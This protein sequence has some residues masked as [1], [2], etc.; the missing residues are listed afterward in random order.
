MRRILNQCANAA[1]KAKGSIFE[2]YY[3]RV[4][5]RLGNNKAVWFVAHKICTVVWVVLHGKKRYIEF[6]PSPN[7]QAMRKRASRL[8]T[9]LRRL[10]YTVIPPA[11]EAV[12]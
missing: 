7:L 11:P 3:S 2:A 8:A 1:V 12:A 4:V 6:G 5:P 10:G 9:Q